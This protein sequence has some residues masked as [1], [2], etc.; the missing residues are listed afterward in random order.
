[1]KVKNLLLGIVVIAA[2]VAIVF[3]AMKMSKEI[4]GNNVN[5]MNAVEV[6]SEEIVEDATNV[7]EEENSTEEGRKEEDEIID[8]NEV[9]GVNEVA[10][11]T[12]EDDEPCGCGC[13]GETDQCCSGDEDEDC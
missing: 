2:I 7:I 5:E 8:E 13:G 10:D 9:T 4:K 11:G 6:K 1:M 12:D 3:F